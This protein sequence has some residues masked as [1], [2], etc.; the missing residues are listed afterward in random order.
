MKRTYAAKNMVKMAN[1]MDLPGDW[2]NKGSPFDNTPFAAVIR[3]SNVMKLRVVEESNNPGRYTVGIYQNIDYGPIKLNTDLPLDKT[4]RL[5]LAFVYENRTMKSIAD[6][7]NMDISL[8]KNTAKRRDSSVYWVP[9][10]RA[11]EPGV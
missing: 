8:T 3:P 9:E 6:G 7:F 4:M 11:W 1:E 2:W 5:A 10:H